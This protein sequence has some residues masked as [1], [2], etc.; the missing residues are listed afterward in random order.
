MKNYGKRKQGD[1]EH[2]VCDGPC[3][4]WG[5]GKGRPQGR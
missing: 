2:K 3:I 5:G 4:R 1:D